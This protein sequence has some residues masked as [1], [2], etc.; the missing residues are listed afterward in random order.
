MRFANQQAYEDYVKQFGVSAETGATPP[1]LLGGKYLAPLPGI[2][3]AIP[4]K[5]PPPKE[6]IDPRPM[7]IG[8]M[9]RQPMAVTPNQTFLDQYGSYGFAPELQNYLAQQAQMATRD[10]GIA[11]QYDPATQTFTGQG[12]GT[13]PVTVS[14]AEMMQRATQGQQPMT[15]GQ[16]V[17][18]RPM[19]MGTVNP[20]ISSQGM[21][22]TG[23][24]GSIGS[25]M[26]QPRPMGIPQFSQPFNLSSYMGQGTGYE[27]LQDVNNQQLFQPFNYSQQSNLYNQFSN[28]FAMRPMFAQLGLSGFGGVQ[29]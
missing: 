21:G 17:A 3:G 14:M 10:A 20:M 4:T 7:P 26:M 16:P 25:P 12:F 8:G 2:S 6:A 23:T 24:F 15:F 27:Q 18:P 11:Y 22:G 19:P 28:P 5:R 29:Y 13:G 1:G 9:I